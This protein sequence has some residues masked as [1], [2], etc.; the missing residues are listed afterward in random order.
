MIIKEKYIK[1]AKLNNLTGSIIFFANKNSEIKNI[2][3]LLSHSQNS[4]LKKSLKNNVKKKEIFSFDISHNQKI[5]IY[6]VKDNKI[7]YEKSGAKLYEFFRNENLTKI[8]IFGDTI[9]T[10]NNVKYLH[11]LVHGMKLKSY[12]FYV[13]NY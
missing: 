13:I 8:N 4:L 7:S 12:S 9:E 2:N 1:S 6:S 5:V 3:N 11:E 10:P